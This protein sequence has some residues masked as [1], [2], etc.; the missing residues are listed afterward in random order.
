M[1][2]TQ[3]SHVFGLW[4]AGTELIW[5]L[6]AKQIPA[7]AFK[8]YSPDYA[9][10]TY[11]VIKVKGKLYA[12]IEKLR[13]YLWRILWQKIIVLFDGLNLNTGEPIR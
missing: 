10:S 4:D 8:I 9:T 3:K 2:S 5:L 11:G 1:F 12:T 6:K 7:S 13:G